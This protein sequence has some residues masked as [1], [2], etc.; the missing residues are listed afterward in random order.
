MC[1]VDARYNQDTTGGNLETR[2]CGKAKKN[3]LFVLYYVIH[4]ILL[5]QYLPCRE[6][7][8]KKELKNQNKK[9]KKVYCFFCFFLNNKSISKEQFL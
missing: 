5:Y 6:N 1:F 8:Q 4:N 9:V 2:F 7:A 3:H